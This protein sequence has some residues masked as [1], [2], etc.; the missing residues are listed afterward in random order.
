MLQIR[1]ALQYIPIFQKIS[2]IRSDQF[3]QIGFRLLSWESCVCNSED[4][5][6]IGKAFC[7]DLT[8]VVKA[9]SLAKN[10]SAAV[11]GANTPSTLQWIIIF[12]QQHEHTPNAQTLVLTRRYDLWGIQCSSNAH[13]LPDQQTRRCGW[14]EMSNG[15]T[16]LLKCARKAASAN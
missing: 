8:K 1:K 11:C 13:P 10:E 16:H 4:R 2:N 14:S 3:Y 7:V 9:S 12:V 5:Q 6:T 15:S